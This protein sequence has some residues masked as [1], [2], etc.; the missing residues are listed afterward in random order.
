MIKVYIASPY[1]IGDKQENVNLQ[2]DA[3]EIL[4]QHGYLGHVPLY[5]HY[6][7]LRHPHSHIDWLKVDFE[8]LDMCDILIRIKPINHETGIEIASPGAD[9]E[10]ARARELGIPV[11]TFATL[12]ELDEFLSTNVLILNPPDSEDEIDPEDV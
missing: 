10:E 5:N 3:A 11:F 6:H 8:W 4:F 2:I 12:I 7:Q 9:G 1:T